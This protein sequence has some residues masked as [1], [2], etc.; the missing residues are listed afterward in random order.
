MNKLIVIFLAL[1]LFACDNRSKFTEANFPVEPEPTTLN[2][3]SEKLYYTN[4]LLI[5]PNTRDCIVE[6]ITDTREQ[7]EVTPMGM[8]CKDALVPYLKLT[9]F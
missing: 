2:V 5:K 4:K 7:C 1:G 8:K 3:S 9:C 6:V